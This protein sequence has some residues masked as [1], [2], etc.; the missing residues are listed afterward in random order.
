MIQTVVSQKISAFLIAVLIISLL[1]GALPQ[2]TQAGP[3]AII[4]AVVVTAV[5]GAAVYDYVSCN[6][7]LL[8]GGCGNGNAGAGGGSGGGLIG[9]TSNNSNSLGGG[10][11]SGNQPGNTF[12]L[13][14]PCSSAE[15]N[16]CGMRGNGFMVNGVC[17]ATPPPNSSCPLPSFG[18][19][20][21]DPSRVKSGNTTSLNWSVS[22]AT[23]CSISGGGLSLSNLGISGTRQTNAITQKTIFTLTCQNGVG[24][25]SSS[26]EAT[27]SIV[28]TYEEI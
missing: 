7:N 27:V 5:A 24:G 9:G 6:L 18:S 14:Q 25:P 2:K 13:A 28:P 12:P 16:S 10:N 20:S 26:K 21:A 3:V 23:V 4:V 15:A 22:N 19:F 17:N 11:N 1:L 8:F